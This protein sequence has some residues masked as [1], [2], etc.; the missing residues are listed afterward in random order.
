TDL[1][2]RLFDFIQEVLLL[3]ARGPL[4][5]EF[6][7]RFQQVTSATMAKGVEDT[8]FYCHVRLVALNEVGGDPGCF[9]VSVDDFH[10]WCESTQQT[11]PSTML[12][13]G[14]HDTK[15]SEDVRTRI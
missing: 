5:S 10:K 13:T 7:M 6:V 3:A 12:S 11:Q 15:R 9:G 14:T 1:D 8:A 4:E 2:S